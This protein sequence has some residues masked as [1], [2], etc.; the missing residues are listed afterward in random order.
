MFIVNIQKTILPLLVRRTQVWQYCLY[1]INDDIY[2][3]AHSSRHGISR[4]EYIISIY[5]YL[6][7]VLVVDSNV[8]K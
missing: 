2:D 5:S 6:I 8:Q 3:I 1:E 7:Q 4:F